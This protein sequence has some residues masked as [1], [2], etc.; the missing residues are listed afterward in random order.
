MNRFSTVK[1]ALG[2][3][4]EETRRPTRKSARRARRFHIPPALESLEMRL[5]LNGNIAITGAWA[6][7][8]SGQP[9]TSVSAGQWVYMTASY[10]TEGLPSDASYSVAFT[11]NGL[12]LDS[13]DVN[14]GAGASG[15]TSWF[16]VWG[17]FIATPGTNQVTAVID[18]DHSVPLASYDDTSMSITFD[19]AVPAVGA[20]TYTVAQIR[21]AYGLN[22]L[23]S[24]GSPAAD[25][26]GQTIALDE[27]GN[28]PNILTDLD[29]FD[30]A[31]S[32]TTTSTETIYQQYGPASSFVTIYNQYGVNITADIADSGSDGVPAED[33]TGHWQ[34]EETLDVEWAHAIAPGAKID[35]IEVNDDSSWA[36]NLLEGDALAAGLPGVSVISNSWGLTE[37]T[38]ETADD[39]SIFV[40]PSGHEGVTFLTASN[41]NGANVYPSPPTDPAPAVGNDG[42]YPATSPNVVAVGGTELT[43]YNDDYGSETGWSYPAP[44]STVTNGSSSYSQTGSW[45]A[46]SGG[47]SGR[48]STAAGG[49][50]SSASWTI[51]VTPANTGW[52]T[53]LSATWTAQSTNATNAT[54]T[55]YDG[56][57]GSGTLLGTVT[58]DQ[59]K[60][61][62]G[63]AT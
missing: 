20:M 40:T 1:G 47:F 50:S 11:V 21:N 17:T 3:R 38:D 6:S 44:A 2:K 56:T 36:S 48:Y 16:V 19:A 9:V 31:M 58:V 15:T 46:L 18:P 26:T 43:I 12:T 35:I 42:Y 45:T 59:T 7:N 60:P 14:Y 51:A 57:P 28:D 33:P 8:S 27:A 34:G 63:T 30:Q 62:S 24:F 29:G 25:G 53:E 49:S 32:L 41:D 39:S 5:T 54:Y 37:W 61:P 22:S 4:L 55:I 13:A 10:T 23:A 52:G